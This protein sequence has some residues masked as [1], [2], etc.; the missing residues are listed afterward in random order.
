[1]AAVRYLPRIIQF[2]GYDPYPEPQSL[3]EK[4]AARRRHMGL[5]RKRLAR[6]LGMDEAT[7]RRFENGASE[8]TGKRLAIL[9]EFE[10]AASETASL[11]DL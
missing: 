10:S 3:G 6:R 5:S 7:L 1:M 8:P 2:L 11:S 4:I 9:I